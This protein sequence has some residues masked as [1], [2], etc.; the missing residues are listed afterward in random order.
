MYKNVLNLGF[1][2]LSNFKGYYRDSDKTKEAVDIHGWLH[3]G[4][5]GTILPNGSV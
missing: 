4:D 3:T 1:R 5:I 2:G